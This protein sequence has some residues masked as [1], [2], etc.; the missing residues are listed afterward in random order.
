MSDKRVKKDITSLSNQQCFDLVSKLEPVS[1]IRKNGNNIRE[2]GF[3]AQ[4]YKKLC[5]QCVAENTDGMLGIATLPLIPDLVGAIKYL[6]ATY[7]SR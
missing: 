4:D 3:I 5:P 7:K 6:D 1:Y 2:H